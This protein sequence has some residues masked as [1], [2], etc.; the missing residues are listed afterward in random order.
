MHDFTFV[1]M[2]DFKCMGM[3]NQEQYIYI[4]IYI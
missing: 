4:Y 1:F 2:S 3:I